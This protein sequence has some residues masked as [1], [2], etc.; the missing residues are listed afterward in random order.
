VHV[1]HDVNADPP[2]FAKVAIEVFGR[3]PRPDIL[4][5]RLPAADAFRE[6]LAY[7]GRAGF[8]VV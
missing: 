2:L 1:R 4:P 8:A 5:D 6:A 7:A 3:S